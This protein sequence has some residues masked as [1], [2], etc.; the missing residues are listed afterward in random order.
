MPIYEYKCLKC[1][2]TFEADQRITD[3]PLKEHDCGGEAQRLISRTSFSLKGSG[4][5]KTDYTDYNMGASA[6]TQ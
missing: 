4:W 1:G 6:S 2:E 3:E 5:Y